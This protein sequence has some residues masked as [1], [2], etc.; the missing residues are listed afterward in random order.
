MDRPRYAY[1]ESRGP[2]WSE[3]VKANFILGRRMAAKEGFNVG[4]VDAHVA[5]VLSDKLGDYG[6]PHERTIRGWVQKD[7]DLP[8]R[9]IELI[10]GEILP[11]LSRYLQRPDVRGD[12]AEMGWCGP[13]VYGPARKPRPDWGALLRAAF[14]AYIGLKALDRLTRTEPAT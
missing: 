5:D 6:M 12:T 7:Q 14:G 13:G 1:M 3:E 4:R 10:E 11:N 9:M 2:W 8:E